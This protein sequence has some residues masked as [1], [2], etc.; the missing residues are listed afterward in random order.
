MGKKHRRFDTSDDDS[1]D[2]DYNA[3]PRKACQT[4]RYTVFELTSPI[5]EKKKS[6]AAMKKAKTKAAI[7]I[8]ATDTPTDEA[9]ARD[10]RLSLIFLTGYNQAPEY[11]Y[12]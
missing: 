2:S 3:A 4:S 5:L 8:R 10:R 7:I 6:R 11:R 1:Q 9:A 12:S